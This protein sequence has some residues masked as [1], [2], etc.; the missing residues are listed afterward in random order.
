MT[1]LLHFMTRHHFLCKITHTSLGFVFVSAF[2]ATLRAAENAATA[3]QGYYRFPAI[4]GSTIVFTAEGDLWRVSAQGGM[5]QRLT[6][7]PG[8][9]SRAAFT[10][11]RKTLAFSAEYTGPTQLHTMPFRVG[12]P[13][14]RDI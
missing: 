13:T 9:E 1:G 10:P 11:D 5:A 7:H 2:L 12:L 3:P 6:S 14:A 4:H 8:T